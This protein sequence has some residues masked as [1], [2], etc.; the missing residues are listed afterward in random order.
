MTMSRK[1]II[2][3]KNKCL[4]KAKGMDV[5]MTKEI[6]SGFSRLFELLIP[7]S[8]EFSKKNYETVFKQQYEE[9][10]PL[11]QAVLQ[12][13]ETAEDKERT[14][15]ELAGVMPGM[16]KEILDQQPSK[17]KKDQILMKHNLGVV[18][19]VIPMFRYGR[20]EAGEIFTDRFVE[21]WNDNGLDTNI[22]KSTYEEILDGFRYRFCYITTAMC[23]VLGRE[24]DCYEL[25]LLRRYRDH[26][27]MKTEEGVAL[28][29]EYYNIAP[30]IVKRIGRRA[31]AVQ[32][33]Q[34]LWEE[35]LSPCVRLLEEGNS[36]AC[37]ELYTAMVKDLSEAFLYTAKDKEE[38]A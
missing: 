36:D 25:Q 19:F 29:K 1:F 27:L 38:T 10:R 35:Y 9:F 15:D 13:Y 20:T 8:G 3:G 11:I 22:G 30:T 7:L 21:L 23:E 24:D 28:V 14:L 5:N 26:E 17:R 18:A 2:T 34:K 16:M 4:N 33:Y 6:Q 37:R 12:E 31:D 32:I